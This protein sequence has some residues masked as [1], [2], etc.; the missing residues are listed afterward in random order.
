MSQ[1]TLKGFIYSGSPTYSDQD[2]NG[3]WHERID[4]LTTVQLQF[5]LNIEDAMYVLLCFYLHCN[6]DEPFLL[7]DT[8]YSKLC[9]LYY[10]DYTN[11]QE[12]YCTGGE[13]IRDTTDVED[14]R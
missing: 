6:I 8:A 10:N 7:E 1:N 12:K 14:Q 2:Y 4:R 9:L 13:I 11:K 5:I 3:G